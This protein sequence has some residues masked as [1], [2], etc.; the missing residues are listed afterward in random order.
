MHVGDD[1]TGLQELSIGVTSI[2]D[3]GNDDE[4][5]IDRRVRA[6]AGALLFPMFMLP[7][8]SM[9]RAVHRA[10]S[11][12]RHQRGGSDQPRGYSQSQ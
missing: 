12:R 10:G 3:P 9:G 7:R 4:R 2:R 11:K 8:S 1:F 6:A 5:T